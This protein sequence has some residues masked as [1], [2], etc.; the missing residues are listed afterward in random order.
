MATVLENTAGTPGDRTEN[1]VS[2][3]QGLTPEIIAR[4]AAP[5]DLEAGHEVRVQQELREGQ[6]AQWLVYTTEEPIRDRLS[7]VD[8]NWSATQASMT[9]GEKFASVTI[10]LTVCGVTRPGV[11]GSSVKRNDDDTDHDVVKAAATDAFKRAARM[12][13]VGS[14][15]LHAPKIYTDWARFPKGA[16]L[17]QKKEVWAAQERAKT[18]AERQFAAWYHQTYGGQAPSQDDRFDNPRRIDTRTTNSTPPSPSPTPPPTPTPTPT[19]KNGRPPSKDIAWQDKIAG[20]DN[21]AWGKFWAEMKRRGLSQDD[22]HMAL[23]VESIKDYTG[24]YA[25]LNEVVKRAQDIVKDGGRITDPLTSDQ[26]QPP[27]QT[28]ERSEAKIG[29]VRLTGNSGSF[30]AARVSVRGVAGS[31]P[32]IQV[33]ALTEDGKIDPMPALSHQASIKDL[34]RWFGAGLPRPIPADWTTV[35]DVDM[36]ESVILIAQWTRVEKIGPALT[37]ITVE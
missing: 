18:E 32:E 7:E 5:L 4:L 25:D 3:G 31:P 15:L 37:G 34:T 26:E 24:T 28:S 17:D 14:Y 12:F 9:V 29:S 27:V 1:A 19:G 22:V 35:Y 36:H 13:G 16:T 20:W 10:H 30:V 2:T 21:K 23:G 33:L 8:P 6:R 11:G